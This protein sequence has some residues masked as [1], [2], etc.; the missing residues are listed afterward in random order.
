MCNKKLQIICMFTYLLFTIIN[1][2]QANTYLLPSKNN[3]LIGKNIIHIVNKNDSS[4][5]AIA[6]K[7]KV[8]LLAMLEANPK[9][10]PWLPKI[11]SVL[12]IPRQMLLPDTI[13]Q[14][15]VINLA[16]LR[17]Y[18]YSKKSQ[19][20]SIYPIGIGQIGNSTPLM[21][22]KINQKIKNPTWIPTNNIRKRYLKEQHI[23]LPPIILSGPKNPMGL[24]ALR[25]SAK[26]GTYLIHGTNANFGI[27]MRVTSGCIRLRNDDI[28]TL[29]NN[30]TVGTNVSI[31][32]EPIKI[33]LESNGKYYLEVHQPLSTNTYDNPQTSFIPL[34]LQMKKTFTLPIINKILLKQIIARRSGIPEIINKIY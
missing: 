8:G 18:H 24:Y 12:I 6:S 28:K 3:R 27:G 2:V 23:N 11:G 20:V 26:H 1:M 25:L 33:S 21:H 5:E 29:F 30:V 31:I 16:E 15:I 14:D 4:L 7:Y 10:D 22:T 13:H 17:L 34:S 19:T 9:L 32:N